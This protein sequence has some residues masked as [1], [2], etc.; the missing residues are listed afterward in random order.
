MRGHIRERSPGHWAI[1]I[2]MRDPATGKRKRKWHSLEANGKREAQIE[3]A[4]LISSIKAGT[5]LEPT[6]QHWRNFWNDG[7]RTPKPTSHRALMNATR[8]SHARI[9]RR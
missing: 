6:R 4:T 8:R 7:W 5:Y 3:C 9:L 1:V 2:D